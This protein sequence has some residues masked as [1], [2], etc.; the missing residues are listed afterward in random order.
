M[1]KV[2]A[3]DRVLTREEYESLI[4]EWYEDYAGGRWKCEAFSENDVVMWLDGMDRQLDDCSLA[5]FWT[6][7][8]RTYA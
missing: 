5:R 4:E 3:R 6:W 1:F 2:Q 8:G 7:Y